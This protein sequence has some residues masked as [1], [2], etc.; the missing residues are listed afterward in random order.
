MLPE[1]AIA[2]R[3]STTRVRARREHR[4]R[5][6]YV[7]LD[8]DGLARWLRHPDVEVI[9]ARATGVVP[10]AQGVTVHC[11]DGLRIAAAVVV[12]GTGARR[13][14][15]GGPPRGPRAEQTAVGVVLPAGFA[16]ADPDTATLMDWR[17]TGPPSFGYTVPL[18]DGTVL[19]E[20]TSLAR[21]PGLSHA[22]LRD[23]L[24]AQL[25]AGA[26]EAAVREER[27][28]IPLDIPPRHTGVPAFGV[29]AGMVHPATGYSLAGALRAAPRVATAIAAAPDPRAALRAAHRALWPPRARAVH[30]LRRYG[31]R[32]LLRM[33]PDA[34]AA[35]FDTFFALPVELQR[36]YLSRGDDPRGTVA[37][38]RRVFLAS[39]PSVRLRLLA[40]STPLRQAN[41]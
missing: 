3:P 36:A 20:E 33:P 15:C 4:V 39:P 2:A 8:N 9:T 28:R 31:L 34:L 29:A 5:R 19:V 38:M 26:A 25:P 37:A 7:V 13:A 16:G 23:R 1:Y 30:A 24:Y 27:V 41:E 40:A 18:G 10:G 22:V 6:R 12:D 32:A 11:A 17:N 21:R 35:F 14:L